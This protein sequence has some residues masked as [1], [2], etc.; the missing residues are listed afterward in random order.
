M[1]IAMHCGPP[2]FSWSH[3]SKQERDAPQISVYRRR[4]ATGTQETSSRCWIQHKR[5]GDWELS[6]KSCTFNYEIDVTIETEITASLL[7]S[8]PYVRFGSLGP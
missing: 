1:Q 2:N 3:R 5:Y 7:F 6:I 4:E 8:T